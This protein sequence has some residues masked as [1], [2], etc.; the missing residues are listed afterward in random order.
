MKRRH[1]AAIIR[2]GNKSGD[3]YR[4]EIERLNAEVKRL[5]FAVAE[6]ENVA[7]R[8]AERLAAAEFQVRELLRG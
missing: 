7:A 2:N 6:K 5:S 3:R 1:A 4:A 8:L